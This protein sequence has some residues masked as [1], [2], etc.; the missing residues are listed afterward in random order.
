MVDLNDYPLLL[1]FAVGLG[2]VLAVSEIGWQLGVRAEGRGSSNLTALESAMLGLRALFAIAAVA[3]AF[4]GFASGLEAKRSRVPVYLMGLV[5]SAV[6]FIIL[7]LDRPSAGFITNN[8][9]PMIDTAATI[10]AFPELK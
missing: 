8:Q 6:I 4:A 10:A 3:G 1:V 7:D 9:Q 5:V 2:V